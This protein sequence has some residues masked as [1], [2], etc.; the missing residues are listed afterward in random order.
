MNVKSNQLFRI[1]D[2][3]TFDIFFIKFNHILDIK[4]IKSINIFLGDDIIKT[5]SKEETFKIL[6]SD[7]EKFFLKICMDDLI[8]NIE[9]NNISILVM[10]D[11]NIDYIISFYE[12]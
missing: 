12:N 8:K 6:E 10:S 11:T 5:L 7:S 9:K 4:E 3:Y 1:P 2:D